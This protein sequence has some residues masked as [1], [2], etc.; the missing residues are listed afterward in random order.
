MGISNH[1]VS[2]LLEDVSFAVEVKAEAALALIYDN[3]DEVSN[4]GDV[5]SR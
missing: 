2:T 1:S 4:R 3:T 5:Q